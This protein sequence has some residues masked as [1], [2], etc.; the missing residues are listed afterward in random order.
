VAKF[1]INRVLWMIPVL[2]L[3]ATVTFFLMH[4]APGSPWDAKAVGGR[5]LDPALQDSFNQHYGLDE[6]V[7]EQYAIYLGNVV[8][9]DFGTSFTRNG[10]SVVGVI[11][12][13]FPYSAK[14][15]IFALVLS[16]LIGIPIG[17]LAALKQNTAIDHG[18]LLLATVGYTLPDFV[19]GIFV[20]IIFAVKLQWVPVLFT[21]WRGY[22]LPSLVLGTGGAA[23]ITR[24]TRASML[25][26]ISQ[27]HVRTARAKGLL[28]RM[29]ILR[30]IVRNGILPV[31]TILG[32]AFA[33]LVTGTIIIERVFGVP[34]MGYL[35]IT[36]V[37]SRDYPV[38]MG[39]TLFYAFLIALGN[40]VVDIAYG[41]ADPRIQSGQG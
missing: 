39:T 7:I 29:V 33:G 8:Q 28:S 34:G 27:E 17:T 2:W 4:A 25:E 15:G 1:I 16:L 19:I 20:I 14:I 21:D 18:S 12:E 40:L 37:T 6:P 35:F 3:V 5:Q 22:I 36:S 32:P 13:G 23:F 38:I 30:H 11:Q 41:F 31:I 10:T 24:L 26:I 9:L